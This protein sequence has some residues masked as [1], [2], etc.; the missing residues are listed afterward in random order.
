[1][2]SSLVETAPLRTPTMQFYK[3]YWSKR[4]S[5]SCAEYLAFDDEQNIE[6]TRALK[7]GCKSLELDVID[8]NNCNSIKLRIDFPTMTQATSESDFGRHRRIIFVK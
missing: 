4:V 5:A 7:G 2:H 8:K 1:M 6:L 3:W